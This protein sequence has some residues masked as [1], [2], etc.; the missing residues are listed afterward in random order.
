L[1]LCALAFYC[2]VLPG[3]RGERLEQLGGKLLAGLPE[4]KTDDPAGRA[5]SLDEPGGSPFDADAVLVPSGE[6]QPGYVRGAVVVAVHGVEAT[7]QTTW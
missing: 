7:P 4:L 5:V 6:A 3:R 2:D 1:P